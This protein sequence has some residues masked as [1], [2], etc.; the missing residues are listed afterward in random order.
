MSYGS[1]LAKLRKEKGYTQPEV[2]AYINKNSRKKYSFTMVSHWEKDVSLPPVEKFLLMCE[3]YE[4]KDIQGTFRSIDSEYHNL[5][6]LNELGKSRVEEYISLLSGNPLFSESDEDDIESPR[7][8]IKLYD[9]PVAAGSGSFLCSEAYEEV[10]IDKTV[11]DDAD[12]AVRVSGD[13]MEPR[14]IDGQIVFVKEQE[15]LD[16]GEVGIFAMNGDAFI[17][18]FGHSELISINPQYEPIKI[19]EFDSFYVFG[20]VVG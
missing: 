9:I 8:Y 16:I 12:F 19:T 7:G 13:S 11:P 6:K 2:A 15:T 1:I 17:K 4:V 5:S 14:F 10:E 18:K 3:L 20:K